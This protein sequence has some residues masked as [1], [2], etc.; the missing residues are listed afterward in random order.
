LLQQ[1]TGSHTTYVENVPEGSDAQ[2][3]IRSLAQSGNKLIVTTS[4]GYMDATLNVARNFP[5]QWF[6][7]IGGYRVAANVSTVYGR[8][9]QPMYL[10]GIVVGS[11]ASTNK[12]GYVAS[13]PIPEVL[14]DINAFALGVRLVNPAAQVRVIWTNAFYDPA[15]ERDAA[16]ALV[17]AGADVLASSMESTM[18]QQTAK[19]LGRLSIGGT[20]DMAAY[21]GDTVL[22]STVWNWGVKYVEIARRIAAGT[23]ASESYW[24]GMADG[25]VSLVPLSARVPASVAACVQSERNQIVLGANPI[26]VGPIYDSFGNLCV[27]DGEVMTDGQLL[28]MAWVVQGVVAS[29]VSRCP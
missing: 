29:N 5:N 9:Y 14:R 13:F 8:M 18:A 19:E 12:I 22:T 10:S 24:G 25:I 21:V 11:M 17:H 27:A 26:F 20:F 4:F 1:E 2:V 15:T 28:G 6:V 3:V 7:H 23:Y 16:T